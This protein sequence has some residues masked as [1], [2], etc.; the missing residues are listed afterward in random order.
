MIG[1][2]SVKQWPSNFVVFSR[3]ITAYLK[4][5]VGGMNDGIDEDPSL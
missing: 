4:A 1:L 2:L 5:G 3:C